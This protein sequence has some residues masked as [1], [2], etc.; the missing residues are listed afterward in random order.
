MDEK[1]T[2]VP[3]DKLCDAKLTVSPVS[4]NVTATPVEMPVPVTSIPVAKEEVF[5]MVMVAD[6][7]VVPLDA[8]VIRAGPPQLVVLIVIV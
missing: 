6:P 1:L 5:A 8:F 4:V 7:A 2:I 3:L